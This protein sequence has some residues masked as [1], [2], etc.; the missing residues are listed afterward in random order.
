[1]SSL[2]NVKA[3][4]LG[5]DY[6]PEYIPYLNSYWRRLLDWSHYQSQKVESALAL[7]SARLNEMHWDWSFL[8]RWKPLAMA[9]AGLFTN[10][11]KYAKIAEESARSCLVGLSRSVVTAEPKVFVKPLSDT[12]IVRYEGL[13]QSVQVPDGPGPSWEGGLR[14][15]DESLKS[16]KSRPRPRYLESGADTKL[17]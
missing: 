14:H 15:T 16:L 10:R 6:S 9:V 13:Y 12:G 17:F 2:S 8:H 5:N 1:V 7:A 3:L 11:Y 4:S